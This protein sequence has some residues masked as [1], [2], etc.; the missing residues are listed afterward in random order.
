MGNQVRK[1]KPLSRKVLEEV[2]DEQE[3]YRFDAESRWEGMC[4][5]KRE[6]SRTDYRKRER[7]CQMGKR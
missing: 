6:E 1:G 7:T 5:S 3:K 4:E 2:E